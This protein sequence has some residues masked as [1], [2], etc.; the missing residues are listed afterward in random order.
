[1]ADNNKVGGGN[2]TRILLTFSIFKMFIGAGYLTSSARKVFN[3]LQHI[4]I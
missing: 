4:F 1:M 2:E 3:Y